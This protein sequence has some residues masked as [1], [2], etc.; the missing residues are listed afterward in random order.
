MVNYLLTRPL[1]P[2]ID[3]RIVSFD[4][5]SNH[6]MLIKADKIRIMGRLLWTI[7]SAY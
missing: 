4:S 6:K 3:S 1:F 7:L 5:N 2:F